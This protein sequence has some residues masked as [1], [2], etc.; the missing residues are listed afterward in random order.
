MTKKIEP[1]LHIENLDGIGVSHYVSLLEYKKMPYLCIIDSI[2]ENEI[3]AYVLDLIEQYDIPL[4]KFFSAVTW[5][6]YDSSQRHSISIEFSK[7]GISEALYP[8]YKTFEISY[9]SRIV[10]NA[11]IKQDHPQK[12]KRR[13]VVPIPE[14]VEIIFK[15]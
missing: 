13:K 3:N 11:F 8:I 12:I 1:K 14:G 4:D 15:K 7:R 9:I 2:T 5:W 10:G 6:F